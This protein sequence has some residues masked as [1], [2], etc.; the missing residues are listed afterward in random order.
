M[1]KHYDLVIVG[2]GIVGAATLKHFV[3]VNPT[4]TVLMIEKEAHSAQH[5]TGRNS[6][7][8]HAGVYYPP[9]SLKAQYCV[10]GLHDTI[11]WCEKAKLP[12]EQCGKLIVATKESE[13]ERLETLF[14][15]CT[16]NGL[17]P[18]R[19]NQ[20]TLH[21]LEPNIVGKEA[22]WVKL[23]GITDYTAVCR[24]FI[25]T[26]LET[27]NVD[28]HYSTRVA[29][30]NETP[31]NVQIGLAQCADKNSE[32]VTRYDVSCDQLVC[33]AGAY[34][35]TLIRAQGLTP[36]FKIMPF[37]GVYYRLSEQFNNIS[38]RLIYPV[39]NPEMPFLG[40]HLTKMIGGYTTV[41]P[42]A[43]L[44]L[45]REAYTSFPSFSEMY[46]TL[47]YR[48]LHK[49]LWQYRKSVVDEIQTSVSKKR[50]AKL[51]KQY[52]PDVS[53]EHFSFYR[54]GIRAQAVT[55]D[56]KLLHDFKFVQTDRV[57]H[58]GNAPSPAATS[59]MPIARAIVEQL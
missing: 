2:A 49:L 5:Q 27:N 34:A 4:K 1:R 42:N 55:D 24:S 10:A 54:P 30:I 7:V 41:G 28:V 20:A 57:L 9:N 43:V 26:A 33:C 58:V 23:T 6:G 36:D 31:N 45:G 25:N 17:S 56:G 14:H 48:G 46:R 35:D 38:E 53:H 39:P 40:V 37:K 16:Q 11:A 52:C 3:Q 32:R 51:V 15:N 13:L 44:A 12:F 59:A 8:I 29:H 19:V 18:E 50:Y 47:S 21:R 22:I